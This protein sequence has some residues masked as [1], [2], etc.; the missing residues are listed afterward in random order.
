MRRVVILG[1]IVTVGLTY[2]FKFEDSRVQVTWTAMVAILIAFNI[3]LILKFGYSE[4]RW[5]RPVGR[6]SVQLG[7]TQQTGPRRRTLRSTGL[8]TVELLESRALL[9]FSTL[10]FSLPDLTITGQAGPRGA[11]GGVLDVSA[12]LQNI[13]SSTITEPLSQLPSTSAPTPGSPYGSTSTADAP[14]TTVEVLISRSP[15]S[16]KGAITLGTIE[17]PPI[18]QNSVEQLTDSFTLPARPAGFPGGGGKFY[19]WFLANSSNSTLEVTR[20]NNLSKPVAVRVTSQALPELRAI[21]LAVPSSLSPGDTITPEIQIENLGTAD[22]E[23]QGPVTVDLVASVTRSFTLGSSIVASYTV[24]SVRAVSEAPT[25]GNYQTF[26][27]LIINQPE[28]VVTISGSA[29]TLPTSPA[30]YYLGVVIDPNG[31][32]NQLSLPKNNFELIHVV[33]P[34]SRHLP[35]AGVVSTPNTGQFPNSPSGTLIGVT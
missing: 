15:K 25:L 24:D 11:W 12:L 4:G 32:I 5:F 18:S 22:P 27:K 1:G 9:A 28:N 29:V 16:I 13:G 35:P 6:S 20:D 30:R 19:V 8:A 23:E 10:G 26:A 21:A 14:D 3:F 2:V 7:R 34:K 33:G 31:T 17:A